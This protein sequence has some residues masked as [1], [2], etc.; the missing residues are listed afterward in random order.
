MEDAAEQLGKAREQQVGEW[1]KELTG[2]MDQS[3]QEMLQLGRE[4]D[5][6]EQQARSGAAPSELRAQQGALQQGVEK[7][8][9]RLQQASTKSNL[10]SQRSLRMMND[11]RKKVEEATAQAQRAQNG[12]Q[13]A[14]AMREAGESLNQ[15]GASLVRDRERTQN[16]ESST[17]FAEML[18]QLQEMARQQ[19]ALNSAAQDLMPK[20]GSK[21][22]GQ[23]QNEARALAQQQREVAAKLEEQGNNDES[24]RAD[25]MARE[26]RQI[27]QQLES[28]NLDAAVLER[29][30]RL[31]RKMLDAGR[32][33]EEDQREDT[34][35]REAISWTG[36]E[37]FTPP[38]GAASGKGASKFTPPT[39]NELRGLTPEERRLV[40]EYFK[41][42]NDKKP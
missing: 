19:Q 25:E 11:A 35:K 13:M 39:W 10:L 22:D 16:S 40:L 28:A 20:P 3:I 9:Q 37:T 12:Q 24:G 31:F 33:L 26:A 17:G 27:A 36:S 7:T 5:K 23:G 6:L 1:K 21:M 34:G 4:Q 2:E 30:Q 14:S 42:I 38:A 29:Q 41:R 8:M 15:A 32:L 18:E